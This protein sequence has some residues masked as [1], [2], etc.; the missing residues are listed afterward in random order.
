MKISFYCAY[1][2]G[3]HTIRDEFFAS[4]RQDGYDGVEVALPS[5]PGGREL[6]LNG[7]EKHGLKLKATCRNM[8]TSDYS[9][10]AR[11]LEACVRSLLDVRPFL[12]S[13]PTGKDHF[14][15]DQNTQLLLMCKRIAQ[16]HRVTI[17]H[18]TQ[19]GRF[20]FAVHITRQYLQA[21]P[22]LSLD[23]DI[24]Q[25][26]IVGGGYL[27]DQA[28]AVDLALSRTAHIRARIGYGQD[29][30]QHVAIWDRVVARYRKMGIDELGFTCGYE[31][32]KLLTSRYVK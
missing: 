7:L 6:V 20:G 21:M 22:S 17:V 23:L 25:W 5:D 24:S 28:E 27:E 18:T 32:K 3:L 19:R 8:E 31:M 12:I 29:I 13:L 10:H 4:A 1:R 26:Y 14:S 11:E 30:R 9:Q 2:S 15:F 16:E